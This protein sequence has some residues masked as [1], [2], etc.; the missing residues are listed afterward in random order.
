VRETHK[1]VWTIFWTGV[2]FAWSVFLLFISMVLPAASSGLVVVYPFHGHPTTPAALVI[3]RCDPCARILSA[4]HVSPPPLLDG[5][6]PPVHLEP[7]SVFPW[8]S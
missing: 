4:L 7:G 3:G 1:A 6:C 2:V 5:R 8:V